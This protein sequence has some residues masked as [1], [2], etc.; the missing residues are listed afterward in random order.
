M[1]ELS[2]PLFE[3]QRDLLERQKEEYRNA[4]MGDVDQLKS[5]GQ[6]IGK[7]VAIAGGVLLAGIMVSRLFKGDPKKKELKQREKQRA[8]EREKQKK[9]NKELLQQQHSS[10]ATSQHASAGVAGYDSMV[11]EM[12]D[13]YTLSS[14]NMPHTSAPH[15]AQHNTQNTGVAKGFMNSELAQVI[16]QQLIA[17]LMLYITKK[18]EEYLSSV[19]KNNDIAA[20]PIEVTEIETTEYIYPEEEDAL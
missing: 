19:S 3:D 18:V 1:S 8:K 17:L 11:H 4:L 14:E 20:R 13:G 2:N 12:E 10:H 16:S 15:Y 9:L 6:D 7:K 5:T